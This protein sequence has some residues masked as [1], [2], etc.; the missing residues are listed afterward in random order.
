[1]AT[2]YTKEEEIWLANNYST[3]KWEE[4][5]SHINKP[6]KSIIKKAWSMGLK[7][8][9][10][11]HSNFTEEEDILIKS[12]WCDYS[13]REF[14]KKFMPYRTTGSVNCRAQRLG[15]KRRTPWSSEEE[16]FL[17][18]HYLSHTVDELAKMLNGRTREAV[19]KKLVN[20]DLTNRPNFKYSDSDLEFVKDNYKRMSDVEIGYA[21]NRSAA[22]IKEFRRKNEL[23]R[24]NPS[25]PTHYESII[26]YVQ[27]NNKEWK[28]KSMERCDYKC[29]LSNGRFE[30][31]HHLYAKNL[32][33][34]EVLSN[35]SFSPVE[36]FNNWS[37]EEK[38][39]F[40]EKFCEQQSKYP[41]GVCLTSQLHKKFHEIYGFG[42]NT[43]EQFLEFAKLY[44]QSSFAINY[45]T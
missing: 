6:K 21:L 15:I 18:E 34:Q 8:N 1:M 5:L 12:L 24:R 27:R 33:I 22:S 14:I 11:R 28:T 16:Q 20:L 7:R 39:S 32:I 3:S 10:V 2:H 41:L 26:K 13:P 29:V 36:D 19:Y 23:Y 25:S 37:E 30:D 45:N 44:S 38:S 4:I 9:K 31:I 40:F 35:N 43:P 42:S 17:K